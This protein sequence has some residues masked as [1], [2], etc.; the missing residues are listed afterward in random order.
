MANNYILPNWSDQQLD[1]RHFKKEWDVKDWQQ[2]D[3]LRSPS[4]TVSDLFWL[5][6]PW[7]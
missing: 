1:I 6:F 4:R 5:K 2:L 3:M 7:D